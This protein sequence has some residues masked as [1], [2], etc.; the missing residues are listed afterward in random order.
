[1]D[2]SSAVP[3]PGK[4]TTRRTFPW[5]ARG[6]VSSGLPFPELVLQHVQRMAKKRVFVVVSGSLAKH[7]DCV[8]SLK[9]ALGDMLVGMNV[10]FPSHTPWTQVLKLAEEM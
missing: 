5:R 2:S 6:L 3:S 8:T 1:M 7:T 10:G 9:E 4:G